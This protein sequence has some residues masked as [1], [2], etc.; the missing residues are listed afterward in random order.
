[1]SKKGVPLSEEHKRK[2][3]KALTGR[4]LS[5]ETIIKLTGRKLSEEHKRNLS[6]AHNGIS[7][8][9]RHKMNI[10]HKG[11]KQT[12][13][14]KR[15][16]GNAKKGDKNPNWLGGISYE[17][18]CPLFNEKKKEE[19]RQQFCR[20]CLLCFMTEEENGQ[21]LDVHHIDYNKDQGCSG[22]EWRLVPLCRSCHMKTNHDREEYERRICI[23]LE[24]L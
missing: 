10:S 9:T 16:I 24:V 7:K 8:E 17:R 1:M 18:Y 2:I 12:E 21:K 5:A 3:S 15:K 14:T 19:I 13:E 23:R 6:K 11:Y 4:K 22:H 20:I